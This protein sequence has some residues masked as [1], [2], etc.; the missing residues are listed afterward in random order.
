MVAVEVNSLQ[1]AV[2]QKLKEWYLSALSQIKAPPEA[3]NRM[4]MGT[5]LGRNTPSITTTSKGSSPA[6]ASSTLER[7]SSGVE[8]VTCVTLTF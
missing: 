1:T 3:S 5:S 6:R 4:D 7:H 2:S 8:K